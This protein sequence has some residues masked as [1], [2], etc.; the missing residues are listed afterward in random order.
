MLNNA[1]HPNALVNIIDRFPNH[2]YIVLNPKP[3]ERSSICYICA[4]QLDGAPDLRAGNV[5]KFITDM[6]YHRAHDEGHARRMAAGRDQLVLAHGLPL[7]APN[8][9]IFE[10]AY[11]CN[12]C[13]LDPQGIPRHKKK[14][15]QPWTIADHLAGADHLRRTGPADRRRALYDLAHANHP[16]RFPGEAW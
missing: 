5:G 11:R 8:G 12:V 6:V 10:E 16:G 1:N 9:P 4:I 15:M 13:A 7:S 3:L 14:H 2:Q